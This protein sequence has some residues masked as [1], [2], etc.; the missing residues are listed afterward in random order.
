MN[1]HGEISNRELDA[2]IDT[3]ETKVEKLEAKIDLVLIRTDELITAYSTAKGITV[4]I[5]WLAS[6]ATAGG[7]V[8]SLLHGKIPS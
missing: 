4:F 8:W 3:L 5:K 6:L 1:G 7:I 2:R